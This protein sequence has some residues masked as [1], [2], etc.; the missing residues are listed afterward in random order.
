MRLL[1]FML[2]FISTLAIGQSK[3]KNFFKAKWKE[4]EQYESYTL[5]DGMGG[6]VLYL[7]PDGTLGFNSWSDYG[8][9]NRYVQ[10]IGHYKK[11]GDTLF[12]DKK[13][14]MD[15]LKNKTAAN[16]SDYLLIFNEVGSVTLLVPP[17]ILSEYNKFLK[18]SLE[19]E[20]QKYQDDI[21]LLKS[22]L[23]EASDNSFQNALD[24]IYGNIFEN[25]GLDLFIGR[26]EPSSSA[27]IGN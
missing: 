14:K 6:Y 1:S 22:L 25:S 9:F 26:T 20:L 15:L 24:Q 12:F 19:T 2:I 23:P 16:P 13:I 4:I 8:G 27:F 7:L 11:S 17:D 3:K 5:S 10:R 21:Q 18:Y